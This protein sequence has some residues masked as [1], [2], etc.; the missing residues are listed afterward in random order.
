MRQA[1]NLRGIKL[2]LFLP[3]I[4]INTSPDNYRTLADGYLMRFDGENW[5]IFGDL[6]QGY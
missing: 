3:D 6:L 2:P 4:T 1:G 5:V